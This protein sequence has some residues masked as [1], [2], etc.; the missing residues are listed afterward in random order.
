ML[1][2]NIV[3][4]EVVLD[5]FVYEVKE[6]GWS[7]GIAISTGDEDY[8][9]EMNEQS[10]LL[11]KEI[12][13]DVRVKGFVTRFPDGRNRIQVTGFEVLQEAFETDSYRDLY[14]EEIE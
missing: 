14:E 3:R 5:G 8:L 7:G 13:N 6:G 10:Q 12:E 11:S 9:V 2:D 4:K 1:D